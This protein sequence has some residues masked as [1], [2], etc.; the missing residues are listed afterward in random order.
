M[1]QRQTRRKA[2]AHTRIQLQEGRERS[3]RPLGSVV[4]TPLPCF[5]SIKS[6]STAERKNFRE[7][8]KEEEERQPKPRLR[9][10]EREEH[11]EAREGAKQGQAGPIHPNS[12]PPLYSLQHPG[13]APRKL[14][15]AAASRHREIPAGKAGGSTPAAQFLAAG[16]PPPIAPAPIAPVRPTEVSLI[17]AVPIGFVSVRAHYPPE[18]RAA[19]ARQRRAGVRDHASI[20][21]GFGRVAQLGSSVCLIRASGDACGVSVIGA[22]PLEMRS[23]AWPACWEFALCRKRHKP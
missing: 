16:P 23:P 5:T 7:E 10:R 20:A 4:P 22:V 11:E 14:E 15:V 18:I 3:K 2:T 13:P 12:T 17:S 19:R 8:K 9:L 1:I 6:N 21:L